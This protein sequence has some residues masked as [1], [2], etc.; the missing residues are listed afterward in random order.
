MNLRE[1]RMQR[2]WQGAFT[3]ARIVSFQSQQVCSAALVRQAGSAPPIASA[4]AM[5]TFAT[6]KRLEQAISL[7]VTGVPIGELLQ[8]LSSARSYT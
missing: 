5:E 7:Q 6:D 2:F 1:Q 3:L 8:K 4:P